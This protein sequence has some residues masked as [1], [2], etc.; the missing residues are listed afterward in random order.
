MEESYVR[1]NDVLGAYGEPRILP[2]QGGGLC[3]GES[4][5]GDVVG[6][7]ALGHAAAEVAQRHR[8]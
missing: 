1:W 3:E 7:D 2:A 4:W 6:I 8:R 5:P